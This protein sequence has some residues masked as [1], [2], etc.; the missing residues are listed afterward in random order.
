MIRT[1]DSIRDSYSICHR[2]ARRSRSNF[3]PCFFL[4]DRPKRRAMEAL[5]AFM[6]H[7]DDLADGTATLAER[8][9]ELSRWK[10]TLEAALDS[11]PESL[12]PD[13]D[14]GILPALVDTVR[15]YRIPSEHLLAV[16]EGVKMDLDG[17]SFETFDDLAEYCHRVATAVGLAC[18]HIWGFND[19]RAFEPARSCGLAFQ[20]T[21]ILRDLA[22]DAAAGRVY[23]PA[24]DLR[25]FDYSAGDLGAG[26]ADQRFEKL[27]QFQ[28]DRV[29][30][31]YRDGVDLFDHLK[32]G[33]QPIF[34]MMTTVY[35]RLFTRI[36]SD[37][38][39]VFRR[40]VRLSP[41]DKLA[42]ATRWILLPPRKPE[43]HCTARSQ[44]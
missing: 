37:P 31:L 3:Y 9:D 25:R 34:G 5:Y 44:D 26:L 21:N 11:R 13:S 20:I 36:R 30:R 29:E 38:A 16:L 22:E 40:R 6:R 42:I 35:H 2:V 43:L 12:H 23:L 39:A 24:E 41:V 1:H 27:M 14:A 10:Q 17:R 7:T 32:P 19:R 28:L 8:R 33:G 18:I 4:L 15:K